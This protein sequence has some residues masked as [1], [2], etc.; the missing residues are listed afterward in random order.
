MSV[1][2]WQQSECSYSGLWLRSFVGFVGSQRQR[3]H[4]PLA[5]RLRPSRLRSARS[6]N[7]RLCTRACVRARVR[8][9]CAVEFHTYTPSHTPSRTDTCTHTVMHPPTPHPTHA[10]T[11]AQVDIPV[12]LAFDPV[13][14]RYAFT[15]PTPGEFAAIP[16][17]G[18][19]CGPCV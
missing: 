11:T 1:W 10:P 2:C 19:V 8:V 6:S 3:S 9:C 14:A 4:R 16:E 15:P 18:E 5:P 13:E 7:G 12:P 17:E